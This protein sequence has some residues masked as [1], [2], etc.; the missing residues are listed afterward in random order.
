MGAPT[1]ESATVGAA[2]GRPCNETIAA[3][4]TGICSLT[5]REGRPLP[6]GHEGNGC[7]KPL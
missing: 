7:A 2:I 4:R 1:G 6:Y 3:C 5:W